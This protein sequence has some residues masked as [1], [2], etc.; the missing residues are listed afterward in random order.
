[1]HDHG[2]EE[3]MMRRVVRGLLTLALT[4]AATWLAGRITDMILG[5]EHS[6]SD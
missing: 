1:M 5:P 2:N 4:T 3:D 6:A